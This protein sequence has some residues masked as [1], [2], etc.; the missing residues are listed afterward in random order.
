MVLEWR[1]SPYHTI[2]KSSVFTSDLG[3]QLYLTVALFTKPSIW[4][5]FFKASQTL[6]SEIQ[7]EKLL[8]A[9]MCVVMENAGAKKAVLLLL[10]DRESRDRSCSLLPSRCHLNIC[11]AVRQRQGP[12]AVVNYVKR[13]WETVVLDNAAVKNDFIAEPYLMQE[14]PKVCCARRC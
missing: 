7:L 5:L 12:A 8:A 13:T 14:S 6:S 9:L 1:K 11:T 4:R 2:N 3:T 10:K